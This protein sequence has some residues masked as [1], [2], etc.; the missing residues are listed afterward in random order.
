MKNENLLHRLLLGCFLSITL[1]TQS[2]SE[3][4]V[5]GVDPNNPN[6][7]TFDAATWTPVAPPVPLTMPSFTVTGAVSITYN[8]DNMSYYALI[9]VSPTARHLATVDPLTGICTN[10]GVLASNSF[11]SMT[12]NSSNG[13][14]YLMGGSGGSAS[15]SERLFS[16][17]L[18]TAATTLLGGPYSIGTFGEVIAYNAT[19]NMIY[20]WS[21]GGME[22][23]DPSTFVATPV[24]MSGASISE[25]QG[26]VWVDDH[27][28]LTDLVFLG[29]TSAFTL[30]AAGVA[31]FVANTIFQVRGLAYFN[32]SVVPVEL[33]D[34][35][36]KIVKNHIEL[37]WTTANELNNAGFEIEKS[38]N[39]SDWE[40]VVFIDGAGTT[41]DYQRYEYADQA[42][43]SG[44]NYYRLKQM[45]FDGRFDYSKVISFNMT[46]NDQVRIYP[47]PASH[48]IEI[49]GIDQGKI[50]M[51]NNLGRMVLQASYP[52]SDIDISALSNGIYFI[53][54]S[55]E[56]ALTT[57]ILIKEE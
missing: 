14:M 10:I 36:G 45:D 39:G 9:K 26:A 30:T 4:L 32:Q 12:Y 48:T 24:V 49:S 8:P 16:V 50:V 23:I 57:K 20:H 33:V 19:D 29:A 22:R 27:F 5:I 28:V 42:P 56:N 21:S 34:F 52:G 15:F 53:Q 17:D 38:K 3:P 7:Q 55:T 44:I 2:K 31:T 18:N 54:I 51:T 43:F 41:H 1:F 6:L 47:N 35:S 11:S 46:A 40:R 13:V 25:V 37:T